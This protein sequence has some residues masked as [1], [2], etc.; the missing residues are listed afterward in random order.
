MHAAASGGERVREEPRAR[1]CLALAV[2]RSSRW[3]ESDWGF[4]ARA[5]CADCLSGG[6]R[7]HGIDASAQ[8]LDAVRKS[9]AWS[10]AVPSLATLVKQTACGSHSRAP[11]LRRRVRTGRDGVLSARARLAAAPCSSRAPRA[12]AVACRPSVAAA[13]SPRAAREMKFGRRL[14]AEQEEAFRPYYLRCAHPDCSAARCIL[15]SQPA[16]RAASLASD[17][18]QCQLQRAQGAAQVRGRGC[19]RA[20]GGA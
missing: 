5:A 9:Y 13:R 19:C 6:S 10:A 3:A 12:S 8:F 7:Q 17:A 20:G 1:K 14:E 4:D 15:A 16:Y 18:R 2:V 11:T